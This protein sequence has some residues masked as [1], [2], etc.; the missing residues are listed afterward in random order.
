MLGTLVTEIKQCVQR[1][2][3]NHGLLLC[4]N[5][6]ERC[7]SCMYSRI[8]G[9]VFSLKKDYKGTQSKQQS[10]LSHQ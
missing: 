2:K 6:V 7:L 5:N 1:K 10:M 4:Q 9:F 3:I 8:N